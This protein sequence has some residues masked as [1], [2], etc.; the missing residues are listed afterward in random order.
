MSSTNFLDPQRSLTTTGLQYLLVQ[1]SSTLYNVHCTLCISVLRCFPHCSYFT[2]L[3]DVSHCL[4][5]LCFSLPPS[6]CRY[7]TPSV[8]IISRYLSSFPFSLSHVVSLSRDLSQRLSASLFVSFS[9]AQFSVFS[10]LSYSRRSCKSST[11]LGALSSPLLLVF[12][13][14]FVYISS[15]LCRPFSAS[16]TARSS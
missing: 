2:F 1:F 16:D 7:L 11:S 13:L 6:I 14:C 3:I 12:V 15:P 4:P 9:N 10:S 5:S 8:L